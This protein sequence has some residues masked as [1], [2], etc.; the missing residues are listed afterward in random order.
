MVDL[1]A[2]RPHARADR[3]Q[4]QPD[5][6]LACRATRRAGVSVRVMDVLEMG[7]DP[8]LVLQNLT[9]AFPTRGAVRFAARRVS[10]SVGP[11]EIVGIVGESGAGKSVTCRAAAG[12]IPSPGEVVEGQICLGD[13]ELTAPQRSNGA[14]SADARS[15]SSFRIPRARSIRYSVSARSSGK[16]QKSC[17]DSDEPTLEPSPLT[18]SDVS[19]RPTRSALL[20]VPSRAIWRHASTSRNRPR[21][22]RRTA[23]PAGRSSPRHRSM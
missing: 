17:V 12:L 14:R 23:L 20:L 1:D 4:L 19:D 10:F 7:S 21:A 3:C 11:G 8:S 18:Y 5:R 6:R 2:A 13:R 16:W 9:I 22:R 15:E